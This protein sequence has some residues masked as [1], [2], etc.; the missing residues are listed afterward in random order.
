M[1]WAITSATEASA[2]RVSSASAWREQRHHPHHPAVDDEGITGE[3]HHTF[4]PRPFLVVDTGIVQD[5]V[6]QVRLPFLSD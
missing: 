1:P 4:P 3:G 2:S 6:G 5:V